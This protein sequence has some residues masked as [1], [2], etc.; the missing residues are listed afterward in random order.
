MHNEA[1]QD[2]L[3]YLIYLKYCMILFW[4]MGLSTGLPLFFVYG[5]LS[6]PD[7]S[8][9]TLDSFSEKYSIQAYQMADDS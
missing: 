4:T 6:Q 2:V 3:F 7:Q 5:R 8:E 9:V 1:G